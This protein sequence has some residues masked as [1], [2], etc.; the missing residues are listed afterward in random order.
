MSL[1]SIERAFANDGE[2]PGAASAELP[3]ANEEHPAPN[4]AQPKPWQDLEAAPQEDIIVLNN[5][6]SGDP[7][8]FIK[9]GIIQLVRKYSLVF[10]FCIIS[11]AI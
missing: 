10:F 5:S 7:T 1:K 2:P 6:D 9:S 4:V 11:L 8:P 3:V